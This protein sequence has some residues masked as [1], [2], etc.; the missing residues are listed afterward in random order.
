MALPPEYRLRH[1]VLERMRL[2]PGLPARELLRSRAAQLLRRL[3][4]VGTRPSLEALADARPRALSILRLLPCISA[5]F[6]M[7]ALPRLSSLRLD[8]FCPLSMELSWPGISRATLVSEPDAIRGTPLELRLHLPDLVALDLRLRHLDERRAV[9]GLARSPPPLL[10]TV[11]FE[12]PPALLEALFEGDLAS[13]LAGFSLRRA[14]P[15]S[16]ALLTRRL[17]ELRRLERLTIATSA[18]PVT[19]RR[20]LAARLRDHVK[21]VRVV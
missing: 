10:Q 7:P 17:S 8:R 12:G 6:E 4:M 20:A 14:D 15:E 9:G 3:D 1:G 18:I 13:H 2:L 5:P 16:I 19:E 21:H 11:T